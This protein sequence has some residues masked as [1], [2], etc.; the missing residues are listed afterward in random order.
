[1]FCVRCRSVYYKAL[2]NGNEVCADHQL[3]R[4]FTSHCTV[5]A[6][7]RVIAYIRWDVYYSASSGVGS[8]GLSS[9]SVS[10]SECTGK[11]GLFIRAACMLST[12]PSLAALP[13]STF[14]L[15][16]QSIC[17]TTCTHSVPHL[18]SPVSPTK[19]APPFFTV[20]RFCSLIFIYVLFSSGNPHSFSMFY[21]LF[22]KRLKV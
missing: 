7:P 2:E 20:T 6:T 11:V 5:L 9:R 21:F 8:L 18:P 14:V 17:P 13:S 22:L 1:M 15:S 16:H 3:L 19:K 10:Q 4:K 12:G